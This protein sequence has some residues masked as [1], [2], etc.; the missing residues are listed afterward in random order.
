MSKP[1]ETIADLVREEVDKLLHNE[2]DTVR[3][4]AVDYICM[5]IADSDRPHYPFQNEIHSLVNEYLHHIYGEDID[6]ARSNAQW[7]KFALEQTFKGRI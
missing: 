1:I 5:C 2:V 6:Q 7:V 4:N 3:E